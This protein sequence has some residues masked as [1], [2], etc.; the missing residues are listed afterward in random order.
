[1]DAIRRDYYLS[2]K[3]LYA[4]KYTVG[5]KPGG[6]AFTW[7]VGVMLSALNA[8]AKWNPKYKLWLQEYADASHVYWNPAPPVAGYDVLPGPKPV[9]RY[10]DDNAWMALALV[11][12]Y[13]ILKDEK[14]LRW[15]EETLAYVLS[16]EDQELGGGIYWKETDKKSKNTC[17]NG[18]SAAACLAVYAHAKNPRFLTRAIGLYYWTKRN[19]QDPDDHLYWDSKGLDGKIGKAKWTYNTA[20]MIRTASELFRLTGNDHYR[21]DV[22]EMVKSSLNHWVTPET[23]AIKDDVKFA[24]LLYESWT[25]AKQLGLWANDIKLELTAPLSYLHDRSRSAEGYFGNR[26]D[27][28]PPT[29][30]DSYALIDQ[31]SAARAFFEGAL[32]QSGR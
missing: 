7:G 17:S 28:L 21:S 18:P 4:D 12:T 16:G 3:S 13:E 22:E 19:L 6:V 8:A 26:W 1:M 27:Q 15:A 32:A 2:D 30:A 10:Y 11:E 23:S 24:H 9:D 25:R 5:R 20:L 14:Y 29:G 31:A